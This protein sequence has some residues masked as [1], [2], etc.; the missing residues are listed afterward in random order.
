MG[1]TVAFE[2][3]GEPINEKHNSDKELFKKI[4]EKSKKLY[5]LNKLKFLDNNF[6]EKITIVKTNQ[7]Y[8]L[9][10]KKIKII[11]D[12]M[13]NNDEELEMVMTYD[14]LA[15]E[16]FI[17]NTLRGR[18]TDHFNNKKVKRDVNYKGIKLLMPDITYIHNRTTVFLE[19]M[20]NRE[21]VKNEQI[22]GLEENNLNFNINFNNENEEN[23]ENKEG[24]NN[25]N[26]NN[27]NENENENE[28][29]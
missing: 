26:E 29:K 3:A 2:Q 6:C 8:K 15:E 9:P 28:N 27:E 22:G 4:L 24:E 19:S 14:N 7:L 25:E 23:N 12:K 16:K 10:L 1:N 18:L 5:D 17:V 13:E 21:L 11:H 20:N